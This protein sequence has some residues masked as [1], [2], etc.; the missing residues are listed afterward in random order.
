MAEKTKRM[1]QV[2][3]LQMSLVSDQKISSESVKNKVSLIN[4][5][6]YI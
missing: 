2:K 6:L 1:S 5:Y 4:Y 3:T